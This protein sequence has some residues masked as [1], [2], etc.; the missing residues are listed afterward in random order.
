M[1]GLL[2]SSGTFIH[3]RAAITSVAGLLMFALV[4]PAN[5][6][7]TSIIGL[8]KTIDDITGKPRGLVRIYESDGEFVGKIER[9]L[10]AQDDPSAICTKCTDARKNQPFVGMVILSG[11]RK[12][13][14]EYIDGEILDP[15]SGRV[16]RARARIE[17]DGNQLD[18]RG[19]IGIELFGRSQVWTR[20]E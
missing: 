9:G 8:W 15:D 18:L 14:D 19:Y 7:Q 20:E 4:H 3:C 10:A 2:L 1:M 6:D 13:G 17:N 12:E 5:A 11:L 16:Y